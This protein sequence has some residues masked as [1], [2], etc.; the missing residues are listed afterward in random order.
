MLPLIHDAPE[1]RDLYAELLLKAMDSRTCSMVHPAYITLLTQLSP[2]E[3]LIFLSLKQ[4]V[5][6]NEKSRRGSCVFSEVR[7]GTYSDGSNR[8]EVQFNS[9]CQKKGFPDSKLSNIWLDN[10]KRLSLVEIH[11]SSEGKIELSDMESPRDAVLKTTEYKDLIMTDF[12]LA[13][14]EACAPIGAEI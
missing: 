11:I 4:L 8:I 1:L 3:A 14:L 13:F 2:Q 7:R 5:D 9:H 10:L 6:N 12:G